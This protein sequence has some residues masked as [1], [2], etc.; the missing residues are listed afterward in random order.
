VPARHASRFNV[1]MHR[2]RSRRRALVV[3]AVL[4][5]AACGSSDAA[6]PPT[7]HTVGGVGALP[8]P[9]PSATSLAE[10]SATTVVA[11]PSG[12]P[13]RSPPERAVDDRRPLGASLEGNRVLVI[14]DSILASISNRYG[15]QLC[16]LLVPRGWVVQVDAEVS[17][18]IEFG[19]RVLDRHGGERWDAAVV[20]LGSN[21]D[22]NRTRPTP[23][24]CSTRTDCT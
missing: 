18:F 8:G 5:L 13:R 19:R 23:S 17:R 10:P 9:L 22:G 4:G 11:A 1:A 20:M 3:A 12:E 6:G 2:S 14:G 21:Y 24:G 15:N 7:P 16:D